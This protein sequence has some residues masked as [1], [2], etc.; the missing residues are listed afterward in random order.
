MPRPLQFTHYF[1][2]RR[3]HFRQCKWDL[4]PGKWDPVNV[5]ETWEHTGLLRAW[6]IFCRVATVSSYA[7][8]IVAPTV[9]E[10]FSGSA[11]R[12]DIQ[13]APNALW[14]TLTRCTVMLL[15][16]PAKRTLQGRE[17]Q[18]IR[19]PGLLGT[20]ETARRA[21]V[22]AGVGIHDVFGKYGAP[23]EARE[24]GESGFVCRCSG[25]NNSV[26]T[27]HFRDMRVRQVFPLYLTNVWKGP[28]AMPMWSKV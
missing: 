28:S 20:N 17:V 1:K 4:G 13:D 15:L 16:Q 22:C 3:R 21:V 25:K 7:L 10:F 27:G 14:C 24:K 19:R 18:H 23:H 5:R 12:T 11:L 6:N 8:I 26:G 9:L 2:C